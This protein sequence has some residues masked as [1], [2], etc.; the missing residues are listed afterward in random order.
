ADGGILVTDHQAGVVRYL[1]PQAPE[2]LAIEASA[3]P[4]SLLPRPTVH[5]R[6][7]LPGRVTVELYRKPKRVRSLQTM[8]SAGDHSY[9]IPGKLA[10]WAFHPTALTIKGSRQV[11]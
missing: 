4:I 10:S 6:S 3:V 5:W 11:A 7:T 9:R 8:T 1:P 2:R